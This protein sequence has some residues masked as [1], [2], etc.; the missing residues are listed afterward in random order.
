MEGGKI[1]EPLVLFCQREERQMIPL[2][3]CLGREWG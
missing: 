3:V 1:P 2:A